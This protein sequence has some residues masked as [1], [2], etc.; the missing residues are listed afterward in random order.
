VRP[1]LPAT[2]ALLIP[3][4][5][6]DPRPCARDTEAVASSYRFRMSSFSS[7][8]ERYAAGVVARASNEGGGA[9]MEVEVDGPDRPE[10]PEGPEGP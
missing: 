9:A 10:G 6:P 4:P 3:K 5:T 8:A 1:L 7:A 2:A